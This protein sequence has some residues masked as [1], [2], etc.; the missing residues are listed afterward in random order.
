MLLSEKINFLQI[1][2]NLDKFGL[3]LNEVF[4]FFKYYLNKNPSQVLL[5]FYK[6]N[7]EIIKNYLNFD[8]ILQILEE[9]LKTNPHIIFLQI[10]RF[11]ELFSDE[12]LQRI[13]EV[14]FNYFKKT[15]GHSE[16]VFE[17]EF[18]Q[19]DAMRCLLLLKQSGL[20]FPVFDNID[21]IYSQHSF[22]TSMIKQG[23]IK[24]LKRI[25][26]NP[27]IENSLNTII[28]ALAIHPFLSLEECSEFRTELLNDLLFFDW[29]IAYKKPE[30]DI[31]YCIGNW[32]LRSCE[33]PEDIFSK[34]MECLDSSAFIFSN[35][36]TEEVFL[37]FI[38][39]LKNINLSNSDKI[40]LF[41]SGLYTCE[42][43]EEY[44]EK[45]NLLISIIGDGKASE[46]LSPQKQ[47]SLS[48]LRSIIQTDAAPLIQ[49]LHWSQRPS[50]TQAII[51]ASFD[52]LTKVNRSDWGL[53]N[54]D[55]SYNMCGINDCQLIKHKIL[56]SV[57]QQ[58]FYILDVGAG[59]FEWCEH[60][61]HFINQDKDLPKEM[62]I[63]II[64]VRGETY[65]GASSYIKGNCTIHR[66]GAFKAEEMLNAFEQ[67]GLNLENKID[68]CISRWSMRHTADPVGSFLQILNGLMK[69]QALLVMDGFYFKFHDSNFGMNEKIGNSNMLQLLL[70]TKSKFLIHP[71]KKN[72]SLNQ[73]ILQK[74]NDSLC[75]LPLTY[76]DNSSIPSIKFEMNSSESQDL[77]ARSSL[78]IGSKNIVVFKR[79]VPRDSYPIPK[80]SLSLYGDYELYKMLKDANVLIRP[81][82]W[83]PIQEEDVLK[84][85]KKLIKQGQTP[86]HLAVES[87]NLLQIDLLLSH[88]VEIN[89][90]DSFGKTPLHIAA[91]IDR[92]GDITKKLL[93][94][95]ASVS[96]QDYKGFT[97]LRYAIEAEN[98]TMIRL[99]IENGAKTT[100][101]D[102]L[103]IQ[104]TR[105]ES[106]V[107]FT[108]LMVSLRS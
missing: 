10:D 54:G 34:W 71:F 85:D 99:L 88:E 17:K 97:P 72:H 70:D 21:L 18:T 23:K 93:A 55:I 22:A 56:A 37:L 58:D 7:I 30:F 82:S 53:Y 59:E 36:K 15:I 2:R 107:L 73:F 68:Y 9:V 61:A 102:A 42:S 35:R 16:F 25:E 45:L 33:C 41:M 4:K 75:K 63:H 19:N 90:A 94:A 39:I 87:E 69:A 104:G 92:A 95:G 96:A 103:A 11:Q 67:R 49:A 43:S 66:F 20:H 12:E 1:L 52:K 26:K 38:L 86:L 105:L 91:F 8:Q 6:G 13:A 46:I 83:K 78:D 5:F 62:K 51:D 14:V 32:F 28:E 84:I 101:E 44:I 31:L 74:S 65:R 80:S 27:N 100:P 48:F 98:A 77:M 3:S 60:V 24:Y 57:D 47:I 29:S 89:C 76:H 50:S 79:H 108:Q 81:L 40:S 106:V 64:G